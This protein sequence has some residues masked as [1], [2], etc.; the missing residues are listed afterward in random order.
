MSRAKSRPALLFM[1][2]S[3]LLLLLLLLHH[4]AHVIESQCAMVSRYT[5]LTLRHGAELLLIW[6]QFMIVVGA[7]RAVGVQ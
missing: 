5:V 2:L 4:G 1:S 3:L 6:Q 7:G